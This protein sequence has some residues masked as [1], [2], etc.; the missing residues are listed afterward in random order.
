MQPQVPQPIRLRHSPK[1]LSM[2]A[3]EHT[4][5]L[6]E[7]FWGPKEGGRADDRHMQ[8][9]RAEDIQQHSV[10]HVRRQTKKRR[11]LLFL[12]LIFPSRNIP[13]ALA[14]C[15]I[16][17]SWAGLFLGRA[18]HG[19]LQDGGNGKTTLLIRLQRASGWL[20]KWTR[21]GTISK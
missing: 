1:C 8:A 11:S 21:A 3:M 6:W 19:R 12:F 4:T 16:A 18:R 13:M 2:E 5:V 7:L 15:C 17:P 14:G 20:T 9:C 10:R